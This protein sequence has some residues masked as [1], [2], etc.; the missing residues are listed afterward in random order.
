MVAVTGAWKKKL[1]WEDTMSKACPADA[2]QK[3]SLVPG[4]VMISL[5]SLRAFVV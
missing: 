1:G 5:D 2:A 4:L 3:K